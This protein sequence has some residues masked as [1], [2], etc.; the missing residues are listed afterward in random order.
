MVEIV[1][2]MER[3]MIIVEK[4]GIN[5]SQMYS[6][7]VYANFLARLYPQENVKFPKL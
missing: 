7:Q 3:I 4:R 1:L 6:A 5:G 2:G